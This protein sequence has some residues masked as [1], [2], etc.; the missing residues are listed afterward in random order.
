MAVRVEAMVQCGSNKGIQHLFTRYRP[1]LDLWMLFDNS[2]TEPRLIAREEVGELRVCDQALF[3]K[4]R[5]G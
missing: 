5:T 4:I 3:A 1:L 2:G